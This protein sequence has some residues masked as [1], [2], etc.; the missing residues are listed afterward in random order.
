MYGIC[1]D[2]EGGMGSTCTVYRFILAVKNFHKFCD[3]L[4]IVKIFFSKLLQLALEIGNDSLTQNK[5]LQQN[6]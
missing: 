1:T 4:F 6:Q 3:S 5:Q 2:M